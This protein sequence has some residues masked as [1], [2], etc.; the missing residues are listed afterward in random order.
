[1]SGR[2]R[3][4]SGSR[5]AFIIRGKRNYEYHLPLEMG[6]GEVYYQNE[7]KIMC[8]PAPVMEKCSEKYY[9]IRPSKEKNGRM[10]GDIAKAFEVPEEEVSRILPPGSVDIVRKVLPKPDTDEEE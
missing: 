1:M 10:A 6:I 7:R 3:C 4:A 5:G 8:A 9:V 2:R